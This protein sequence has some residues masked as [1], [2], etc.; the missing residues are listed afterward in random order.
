MRTYKD[1]IA[2]FSSSTSILSI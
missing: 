2:N 1:N